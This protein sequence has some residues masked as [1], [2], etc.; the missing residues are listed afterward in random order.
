MSETQSP[1]LVTAVIVCHNDGR[2]LPRC[3]ESLRAQ[4]IFDRLELVIAD[5]VSEDGSDKLAR[6]LIA[7]WPNAQF[8]PT[9]GDNGFGVACNLAAQRASGK[10]LYLLN[11]DTWLE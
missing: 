10:Y 4:T 3:L 1:F 8:F 7:H 2:W 5:N 11:P 9:G 6:N